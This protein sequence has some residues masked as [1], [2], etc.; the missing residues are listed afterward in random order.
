MDGEKAYKKSANTPDLKPYNLLDH[1]KTRKPRKTPVNTIGI[2][3]QNTIL[4]TLST[5][6][7]N[8]NCLPNSVRLI[9]AQEG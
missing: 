9:P 2:L 3:D 5:L 8:K 6:S 1:K 4:S 7:T